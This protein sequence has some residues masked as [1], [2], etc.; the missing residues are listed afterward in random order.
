LIFLYMGA[1]A[2]EDVLPWVKC[3]TNESTDQ[4]H[5]FRCFFVL[6]SCTHITHLKSESM[7]KSKRTIKQERLERLERLKK[8]PDPTKLAAHLAKERGYTKKYQEK[9][10]LDPIKLAA[11]RAKT[12]VRQARFKQ[13]RKHELEKTMFDPSNPRPLTAEFN[14]PPPAFVQQPPNSSTEPPVPMNSSPPPFQIP[15]GVPQQPPRQTPLHLLVLAAIS[16]HHLLLLASKVHSS[17]RSWIP[18]K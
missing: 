8:D 9:V 13:K 12:A 6:G 10:K 5:N 14:Q 18:T 2:E 17:Q 16:Q 15:F 11:Q 3:K 4:T 7:A 1:Q